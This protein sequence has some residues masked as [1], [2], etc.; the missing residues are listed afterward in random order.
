MQAD[1]DETMSFVNGVVKVF[2]TDP[3]TGDTLIMEHEH[4][5]K[6]ISSGEIFKTDGAEYIFCPKG[7]LNE[8]PP[9]YDLC[10]CGHNF[11]TVKL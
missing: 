1:E 3:A 11:G 7:H 2:V 5:K 9:K 8:Y 6:L 4:M 10:L